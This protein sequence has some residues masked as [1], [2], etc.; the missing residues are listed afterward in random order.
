MSLKLF[1]IS[2]IPLNFASNIP[3]PSNKKAQYPVS[4]Y[5]L[6][7]PQS[8]YLK[9]TEKN[10]K[11]FIKLSKIKSEDSENWTKKTEI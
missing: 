6:N 7:K 8:S 5:T 9:K 4:Q 2:R 3:Y 11:I 1:E 10:N